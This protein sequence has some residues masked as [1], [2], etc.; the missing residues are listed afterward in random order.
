MLTKI[1]SPFDNIVDSL[2]DTSEYSSSWQLTSTSNDIV[3]CCDRY[4]LILDTPGMSKKD[5]SIK[6]E[7][8]KL[9][10]SFDNST[11]YDDSVKVLTK[12]T[13][14]GKFE[15]TYLLPE[16]VDTDGI[17]AKCKDGVLTVTLPMTTKAQGK[18][19]TVG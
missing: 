12:N 6:T 15:Q 5:I 8:G 18:L 11:K 19:I 10:V 9:M 17:E 13:K 2:F 7:R 16:D 14:R 1:R 3:Q 4:E